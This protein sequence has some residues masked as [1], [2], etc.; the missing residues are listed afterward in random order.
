MKNCGMRRERSNKKEK[1]STAKIASAIICGN[2][3]DAPN[4]IEPKLIV[5][6]K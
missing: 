6:D 5:I 2:R 1:S 4:I 3:V